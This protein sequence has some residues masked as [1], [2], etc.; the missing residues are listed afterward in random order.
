MKTLLLGGAAAVALTSGSYATIEH[1]TLS[2]LGAHGTAQRAVH[3]PPKGTATLYD[4]NIGD[5]G[6]GFFSQAMSSYPQYDEYL[7]DDFVVP[8]GHTWKVSGV[9][10]SGF[11]Y[12]ESGPATSVNVIVW[13]DNKQNKGWPDKNSKV[14]ECDNLIPVSGLDTGVFQIKLDSKTCPVSLP[15]GRYWLTVQANMTG[16]FLSGYWAWTANSTVANDTSAGWWYGGGMVTKDPKCLQ[17]FRPLSLCTGSNLDLAFA[18][19][20]KDSH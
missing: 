16:P 13:N 11:Y 2:A 9:D 17:R 3:A 10:V 8:D 4:Q 1:L 12:I 5:T 7:A 20:G 6:Y 14:A 19:L 18:L 15:A